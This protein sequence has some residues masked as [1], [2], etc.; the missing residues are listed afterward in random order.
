MSNTMKA[1]MA[2]EKHFS[3]KLNKAVRRGLLGAVQYMQPL[4]LTERELKQ[5]DKR[6][7]IRGT[8]VTQ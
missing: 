6:G 2:E 5:L 8:L 3:S 4:N 7:S 1:I